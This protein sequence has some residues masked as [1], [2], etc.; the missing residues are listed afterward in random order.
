MTQ[1]NKSINENS[2][3]CCTEN[4]IYLLDENLNILLEKERH[5]TMK[6]FEFIDN[7]LTYTFNNKI[8]TEEII[9]PI[10]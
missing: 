8:I 1:S 10:K 3:I 7:K 5:K 6:N 2:I 4:K 9:E